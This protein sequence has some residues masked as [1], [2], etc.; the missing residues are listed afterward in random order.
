MGQGLVGIGWDQ[1]LAGRGQAAS[2]NGGPAPGDGFQGKTPVFRR[3]CGQ[4][5]CSL[6]RIIVLGR[7]VTQG[8]SRRNKIDLGSKIQALA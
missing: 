8:P 3:T 6:G 1:P 4:S 5:R 2:D 7:E